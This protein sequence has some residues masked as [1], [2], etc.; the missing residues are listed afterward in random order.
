MHP[1]HIPRGIDIPETDKLMIPETRIQLHKAYHFGSSFHLTEPQMQQLIRRFRRHSPDE[2]PPGLEGRN[3][4]SSL[5]LEG[6]GPV[7]IKHYRRGGLV[8]HLMKRRYF[9][10]RKTRC[11]SEYDLLCSVR[12]LGIHAPEPVAFAYRGRLVYLAWLITRQIEH[13]QSLARISLKDEKRARRVMKSVVA[14]SLL[15]IDHHIRHVD[16]HPGNVVVDRDDRVFLLD[17]DRGYIDACSTDKLRHF[18]AARWRR[19]VSKHH[20]PKML[21]E[22]LDDGLKISSC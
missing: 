9:T 13:P 19:A 20:L 22:M 15:L 5:E 14:Q 4:V 21:S 7:V 10:G 1:V 12:D 11:Q 3:P 8:R 18:Y 17:F 6:I 16:L 2:L